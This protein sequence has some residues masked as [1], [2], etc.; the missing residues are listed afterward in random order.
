MDFD[1]TL[2]KNA[3]PNIGKPKM[4]VINKVKKAKNEGATII[5]WTCR[6][7]ASLD[8]AVEW[9]NNIG[10]KFD[11]INENPV[12]QQEIFNSDPRKIG[13]TEYWDDKCVYPGVLGKTVLSIS[14]LNKIKKVVSKCR[15]MK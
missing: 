4:N 7:G 15:I 9:C 2:C 11:C 10:L 8:R 12:S 1:G 3:Y 13:A 14:F 6:E 5:L